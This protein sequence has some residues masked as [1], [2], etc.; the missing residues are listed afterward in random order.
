MRISLIF[1]FLLLFLANTVAQDINQNQPDINWKVLKTEHFKIIF[2]E[3]IETEAQRV[4]NT[5]EFLR[6]PLQKTQNTEMTKWP[7]ILST[8]ASVANGYVTL[9]PKRSEWY[10][11]SPQGSLLGTGEWY[12]LLASHEG[13]HM[14][15]YDKMDHGLTRLAHILFG[16]TAANGLSF[17]SV[18]SWYWE[19][20]AVGTETAL[21]STG[22]GRI[23]AFDMHTRTLLLSDINYSFYKAA[24][25]SF[26]DYYP[27]HYTLGYH[28]TTHVKRNYPVESWSTI[29]RR[30]ANFSVSPFRFSRMMRLTTGF[31]ARRTYNNTMEE[32]DSLWTKKLE[33]LQITDSKQLS[34]EKQKV[35]TNYKYPYDAG[36]FIICV[37]SG[38]ADAYQLVKIDKKTGQEEK[39]RQAAAYDGYSSAGDF[40]CWNEYHSDHRYVNQNYSDIVLYS[41]SSKKVN[42]L[43]EKGR[44]FVPALSPDAKQIVAVK[45]SPLRE[46][47]LVIIDTESGKEISQIPNPENEFIQTPKW[48]EDGKKIVYTKQK[49]DG[50]SLVIYDMDSK[51][52]KVII[53]SGWENIANPIFYGDLILY[54]SAYTGIDNIYAINITNGKRYQISSKKFGSFNPAVSKDGNTLYFASYDVKG[55]SLHAMTLNPSKWIPID[56]IQNRDIHYYEPMISQEQ[57][58]SILDGTDQIP[59]I[60]YE[61]KPY[62]H[63]TNL[64]HI[65]DWS[66]L[67]IPPDI[68]F[69][70]TSTN[71]LNTT[72]LDLGTLFNSNEKTFYNSLN[73][74]YARYYPIFTGGI[75]IGE[76]TIKFDSPTT[77]ED[78]TDTWKETVFGL[79]IS[80]PYVCSKGNWT[81]QAMGKIGLAYTSVSDGLYIAETQT[82]FNGVFIP[83]SGNIYF[84][85]IMHSAQRDLHP[86]FAQALNFWVNGTPFKGDFR[87]EHISLNSKF[88]FPGF[89]RHHSSVFE[90]AFE[91]QNPDNYY[92]QSKII[93]SRG[94]QYQY[95][96]RVF[97][98]SA[99]YELPLFYPDF[100]LGYLLFIRRV[101]A[102]LFYDYGQGQTGNLTS[103]F[104]SVS[105]ELNFNFTVFNIP[106]YLDTGLRFTYQLSTG[107]IV[108]DFLFVDIPL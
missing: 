32:L 79:N 5:M 6:E 17:F 1:S 60:S 78:T 11:A 63:F 74:S 58:K 22:R 104:N 85:N 81:R 12:N 84:S 107:D 27:N 38:L 26:K 53:P 69:S 80:V 57:G 64:L 67:P 55:H 47:N 68:N 44:Y 45:Y 56:Q 23:P 90:A 54:E 95:F 49:F 30:T 46:C 86:R 66:I 7:I 89:A 75:G 96:D 82:D 73:F 61:S 16:Q 52:E 77:E 4:A 24:C 103:E 93:A 29:T 62:K 101:S 91:N 72:R 71:L 42:Y 106:A 28:L 48:S 13:R 50:K 41:M 36:D 37:K 25:R 2:P 51:T 100:H 87:G 83:F 88:Y 31:N 19:G 3:S 76:R 21:S 105:L 99:G 97:R 8:N 15:Q 108:W 18:P 34:P 102:G 92:F 14:V 39:I 70:I 59:K 10:A 40:I 9:A 98:L 94:Y 43:S 65:H 35:W 33:G 20:D